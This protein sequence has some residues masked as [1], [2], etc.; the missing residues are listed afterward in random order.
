[1]NSSAIERD[2]ATNWRLLL[3]DQLERDELYE[4]LRL[5]IEVFVVEQACAF[6]DLD[7]YDLVAEHLLGRAA[8]GRLLAYARLLPPGAKYREA[9]IGRLVTAPAVRARGLGRALMARALIACRNRWP[10]PIRIGAQ[11]RLQPFYEQYG[12]AVAGPP[13]LEDGIWHV[14]M[15]SPS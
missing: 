5:R 9:S 7:G 13:Y 4:L 15:K 1:M 11:Q 3:W 12:F 8:D 14:E 2:A 6:Q 10:G